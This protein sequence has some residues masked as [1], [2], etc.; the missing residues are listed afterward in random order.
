MNEPRSVLP[1]NE[2]AYAPIE[3]ADNRMPVP[4]RPVPK[5]YWDRT[6][7]PTPREVRCP[8]APS[9]TPGTGTCGAGVVA[10]WARHP[11]TAERPPPRWGD[12]RHAAR[13]RVRGVAPR[14]SASVV[15]LADHGPSGSERQHRGDRAGHHQEHE[16]P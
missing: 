13:G 7:L 15:V 5:S 1:S 14:G 12:G 9:G 8:W 3:R 6:G 2:I 11:D 16:P 10:A 4:G